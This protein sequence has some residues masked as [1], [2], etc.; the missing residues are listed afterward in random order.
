MNKN[1]LASRNCQ[2]GFISKHCLVNFITLVLTHLV[3]QEGRKYGQ[4]SICSPRSSKIVTRCL[5]I[6]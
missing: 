1:C 6:E 5:V 3:R 4:K 2:V